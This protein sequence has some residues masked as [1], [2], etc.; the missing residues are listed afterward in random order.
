VHTV[1]LAA[2][3]SQIGKLGVRRE[4]LASAERH[5]P[6]QIREMQRHIDHADRILHEIAFHLPVRATVVQMHERLD[7]TGYPK[8]LSGTQIRRE[9]R[10]LG[11]VDVFCAR[12][13]P[14]SYRPPIAVEEALAVLR[15]H[16]E[17]YDAE[18]IA[19]L[20]RVVVSPEGEKALAGLD[21]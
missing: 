6:E 3:L 19:A 14:R 10:V 4:L 7:G 5:G 11:A 9:A 15:D 1:A 17:R 8:G 21:A 20:A 13:E 18:V 16:P 2:R 12:I